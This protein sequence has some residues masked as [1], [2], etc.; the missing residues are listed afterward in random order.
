LIDAEFWRSTIP[1][2]LHFVM[3][4]RPS[5]SCTLFKG[6][7][8]KRF[9]FSLTL[10]EQYEAV[11]IELFSAR[12]SI[13]GGDPYLDVSEVVHDLGDSHRSHLIHCCSSSVRC[14]MDP[15]KD[16]DTNSLFGIDL[17]PSA[18]TDV[19][20]WGALIVQDRR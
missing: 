2:Q 9:G 5:A 18:M 4:L 10:P 12:L 6:L 3:L 19:R 15:I 16:Q 14:W 17:R 13:D 20:S 7:V 1:F 8:E 11:F